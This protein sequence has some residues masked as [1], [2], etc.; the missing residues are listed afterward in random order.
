MKTVKKYGRVW[1]AAAVLMLYF[2]SVVNQLLSF[3][4]PLQF[5]KMDFRI[6][7]LGLQL[8]FFSAG[9]LFSRVLL[10][11]LIR[12]ENMKKFAA[13]GLGLMAVACSGFLL[14]TEAIP[15]M[16]CRILQ[17]TAFGIASSAVPSVAMRFIETENGFRLVCLLAVLAAMAGFLLCMWIPAAENGGNAVE[18]QKKG[19]PGKTAVYLFLRL[20][21]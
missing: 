2:T 12:E 4:L 20:L 19:L 5:E 16:L 8:S 21:F 11:N 1:T 18:K 10:L 15:A 3:V 9:A 17:G 13:F 6:A 7:A 14:F